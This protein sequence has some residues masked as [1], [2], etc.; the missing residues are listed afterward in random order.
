MSKSTNSL[1]LSPRLSVF[2]DARFTRTTHHDGIS[3]YGS[4]LLSALLTAVEGTEIDVTVIISDQAQLALLPDCSWI[5]LND[6]TS[7]AEVTVAG[8]LNALGADVVFSTMQTM[9]SFGR[10]YGLILTVHDLIYYSHPK[11][12]S[13]LPLPIRLLWRAYHLSFA[14]QRLLLNRADAVAAVSE[15]TKD[16]IAAH[17]LTDR[18]VQVVS[19]AAE[20]PATAA[21]TV[22]RHDAN[23]LIYMGAFLPYKN[24]EALIRALEHLPGWTL[25]IASRID[26]RREAQ[27]RALIPGR[28]KVVFHRGIS[29]EVYAR[30]LEE[31]TALV[32]ASRE[33]GFGLPVIEAMAQGVPVAVSDI[34]IFREIA[35]EAAEY[36]DPE[37]PQSVA[38]AI[39]RLTD[40]GR[41]AEQSAAGQ[42]QS[43][44]F[45]WTK[46]AE[47]LVELIRSVA[48][49]RESDG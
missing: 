3:R 22:N 34:P 47:S 32:T 24:V 38:E 16:L 19:N 43:Q 33:E 20:V 29:D 12:P 39:T 7:P 31:S 13:D 26:G 46:S 2:Y 8:K 49:N 11:P 48:A 44:V 42:R 17:R 36:F 25:H 14:P 9:G 4:C 18:P 6:P 37:D 40:A 10:R 1:H 27:L 21:R 41:W 5:E 30:L 35:A 15:T 23:T 45:D 28:A